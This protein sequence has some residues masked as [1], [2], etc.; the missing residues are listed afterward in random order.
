MGCPATRST[1]FAPALLADALAS[2]H[3]AG[4]RHGE[5]KPSATDS[6]RFLNLQ[7]LIQ[8]EGRVRQPRQG[9][10]RPCAR[11]CPRIRGRECPWSGGSLG[12]DRR[13]TVET[14]ARGGRLGSHA[15][16]AGDA[17]RGSNVRYER[18]EA[19]AALASGCGPQLVVLGLAGIVYD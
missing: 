7:R 10:P 16:S 18:R 2:V 13:P 4:Y 6:V 19:A 14:G 1:R 12:G 17:Q 11:R 15:V 3:E 5:V 8:I 9:C